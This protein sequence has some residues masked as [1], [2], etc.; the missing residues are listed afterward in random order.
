[1]IRDGQNTLALLDL[2]LTDAHLIVHDP[3]LLGPRLDR[4]VVVSLAGLFGRV[5]HGLAEVGRLALR[6]VVGLELGRVPQ[7]Q[8]HVG[9]LGRRLDGTRSPGGAFA[10]VGEFDVVVVGGRVHGAL[11]VGA[12]SIVVGRE[13]VDERLHGHVEERMINRGENEEDDHEDE[14][15][16]GGADGKEADEADF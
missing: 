6:H 8:Q 9:Y 1:M 3:E 12:G 13:V 5:L 14:G 10:R 15:S 2:L 4:W 11:L 16:D 7:L